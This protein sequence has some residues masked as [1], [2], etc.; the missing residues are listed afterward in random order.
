MFAIGSLD[1]YF[2]D[3]YTDLVAATIIAKSRC[4]TMTLPDFFYEILVPVG[5]AV[6]SYASNENWR[7]RMAARRMMERENVLSLSA[8][9]GLFNKFFRKGRRFFG[10]VLDL[11]MRDPSATT[12]MFGITSH[13]YAA[14][15]TPADRETARKQ[16]RTQMEDRF[17]S[18]FQRRHDCIH[19]CDRPR[20]SPQPMTL[21]A[22]VKKVARDV[23]FLVTRC[24]AHIQAEFRV[25]LSGC[26]CP[27]AVVAAAGY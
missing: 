10:D 27:N 1:A 12:R 18:L 7:W 16:A 9:Q 2:S 13:E 23:E 19:N 11:W 21:P 3:A 17:R 26:G 6:A 14:L 22:T 15:P 5:D 24:D 8:V 4:A 20:V 25:F